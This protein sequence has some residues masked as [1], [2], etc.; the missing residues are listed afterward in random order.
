ML[1][2]GV[3][4][5]SVSPGAGCAPW[6]C[7]MFTRK[8]ITPMKPTALCDKGPVLQG[9]V[10]AGSS[11]MH[12]T[13]TSP[14][15]GGKYSECGHTHA[16]SLTHTNARNPTSAV[17]IQFWVEWQSLSSSES[18]MLCTW[19]HGECYIIEPLENAAEVCLC[20]L[21]TLCQAQWKGRKKREQA[22]N[23]ERRN[24]LKTLQ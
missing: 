21:V 23:R 3:A 6:T 8:C 7:A 19:S 11:H 18:G 9:W 1:E 22:D 20:R 4:W 17:H 12:I 15:C 10:W 5:G 14:V 24:F 16:H 2:L 13:Q